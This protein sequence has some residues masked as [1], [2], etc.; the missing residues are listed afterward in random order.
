MTPVHNSRNNNSNESQHQT[1]YRLLDTLLSSTQVPTP[2]CYACSIS[3]DTPSL[4]LLLSQAHDVI[5]GEK[6]CYAL[7]TP[8]EEAVAIQPA[9][10]QCKTVGCQQ[11][12]LSPPARPQKP[13]QRTSQPFDVEHGLVQRLVYLQQTIFWRDS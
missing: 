3:Q 13:F 7:P 2:T 8:P 5:T 1:C 4:Q 9:S 10:K 6:V 11:T 12:R